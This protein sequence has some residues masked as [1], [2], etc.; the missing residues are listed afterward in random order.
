[1]ATEDVASERRYY[2]LERNNSWVPAFAGTSQA[3]RTH[4]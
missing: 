3:V 1:M 4:P 2:K